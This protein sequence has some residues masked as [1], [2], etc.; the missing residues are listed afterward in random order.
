MQMRWA[1]P[2]LRD[3]WYNLSEMPDLHYI[4]K[5]RGLPLVL[6]H[7]FPVDARMWKGQIDALSDRFRVIA[8]DLPGFGK[9]AAAREMSMDSMA[10]T[11]H[12][13]LKEIG[14]LPCVLGGCSLGGYV[15]LAFYQHFP[16][17]VENLILI[18]TRA[19]GDT[20]EGKKKRSEMV[21]NLDRCGPGSV[22]DAM[23]PKALS[24]Q[25]V[26]AQPHLVEEVRK[27]M[28]ECPPATM[29]QAILAMCDR[30]D[31]TEL[32]ASIAEPVLIVVGE[33]DGVTPPEEAKKM[34]AAMPHAQLSII[35]DAAHYSPTENPQAVNEAIRGFLNSV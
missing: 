3:C 26:K 4:E 11:V 27:M 6:L 10:H 16:S 32:L 15:S 1:M 19:T 23:M 28:Q 30:P 8:V 21:E 18:D 17:E 7:A 13:L 14:A 31:R 33:C 35:P 24:D 22:V 5:G 9:S 12:G 29:R 2:T 25:T 20:A 34:Q